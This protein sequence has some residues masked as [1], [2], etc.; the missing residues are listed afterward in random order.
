MLTAK[1][2]A[3][4]TIYRA[5]AADE[6][7]T[8]DGAVSRAWTSFHADRDRRNHRFAA[9]ADKLQPAMEWI[10]YFA[11]AGTGGA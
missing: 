6:A 1:E 5:L 3:L 7:V 2:R 8:V 10:G 4:L 9:A 11:N